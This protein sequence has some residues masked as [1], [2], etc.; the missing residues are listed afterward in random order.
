M[1]D[2]NTIIR[3]RGNLAN[4]YPSTQEGIWEIRGEDPN[5][6]MG[7]CH[8]QPSLGYYEGTYGNVLEYALKLRGFFQWGAGGNVVPIKISKIDEKS[9]QELV[10]ARTE[11]E[12]AERAFKA[13]KEKLEK[14]G[15][16]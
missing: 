15:G 10:A 16:G 1:T 11:L 12:I 13:A 2:S 8:S 7:G 3:A 5:C 4:K 9:T 6:D 14:L